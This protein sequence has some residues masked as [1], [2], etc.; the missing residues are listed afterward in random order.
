MNVCMIVWNL[1]CL[2]TPF[3][4]HAT[5]KAKWYGSCLY[6]FP[7][8]GISVPFQGCMVPLLES[9]YMLDYK[10]VTKVYKYKGLFTMSLS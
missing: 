2:T 3:I 7:P 9:N 8:C 5:G 6:I 1:N 4:K 10:L